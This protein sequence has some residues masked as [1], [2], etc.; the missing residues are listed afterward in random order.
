MYIRGN[1]CGSYWLAFIIVVNVYAL[2]MHKGIAH[3]MERGSW[4]CIRT[5]TSVLQCTLRVCIID[6]FGD[7]MQLIFLML[8]VSYSLCIFQLICP[9][10]FQMSYIDMSDQRGFHVC[11]YAQVLERG[12]CATFPSSTIHFI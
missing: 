6:R 3:L 1:T 2:R 9:C 10:F 12:A 11:V 8:S 4:F 5:Q 7:M